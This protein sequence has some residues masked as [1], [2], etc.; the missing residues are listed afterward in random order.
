ME[1]DEEWFGGLATRVI[2]KCRLVRRIGIAGVFDRPNFAWPTF[3]F[4]RLGDNR[5]GRRLLRVQPTA[6]I[7]CDPKESYIVQPCDCKKSEKH[8]YFSQRKFP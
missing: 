6:E 2:E 7:E 4:F 8:S 3:D 1:C 5:F